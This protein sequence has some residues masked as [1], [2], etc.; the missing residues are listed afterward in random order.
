MAARP[1]SPPIV[2][3]NIDASLPPNPPQLKTPHDAIAVFVHACMLSVGF[4]LVGLSEDDH[5]GP[6]SILL[7]HS[8]THTR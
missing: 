6:H 3:R 7:P 4:R 2:L 5:I 8:L 1:F